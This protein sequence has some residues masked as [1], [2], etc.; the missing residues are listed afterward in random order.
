MSQSHSKNWLRFATRWLAIAIIVAAGAF[1]QAA[2]SGLQLWELSPSEAQIGSKVEIMGSG[3]STTPSLNLVVFPGK[4]NTTA[5]ATVN[6]AASNKLV[7]TVPA[8]SVTGPVYVRMGALTSN[9]LNFVMR[10][11]ITVSAGPNQAIVLPSGVSLHGTAYSDSNAGGK[12][13]PS[14]SQV[15]GPGLVAFSNPSSFDTS[16]TFS[17]AGIYVLRLSVSNNVQAGS[18]DVTI[19]AAPTFNVSAGPLQNLRLPGSLTIS[20]TAS[21]FP[22]SPGFTVFWEKVSGPGI[23]TFSNPAS[24]A[25]NV[26]F[27]AVGTYVLRLNAIDGPFN[28]S[29]D[30]GVIVSPTV[31]ASAGSDQQIKLPSSATL[32]GEINEIPSSPNLS[33]SWSK[34]SGPGEVSFA[35]PSAAV[36]TATFSAWGTYVLRLTASDGTYSSNSETTVT[37]IPTI[38]SVA[39]AN[40]FV[41]LPAAAPL[42]GAATEIPAN[43]G[44]SLSWS[45][46]SGPGDVAFANPSSAATTAT[47]SAWGT[48]VLRLTAT[49]GPHSTSSDTTITAAPTITVNAGQDQNVKLPAGVNLSGTVSETPA[50]AGI[51]VLWS[52][53]SGPG[54][55]IFGTPSATSTTASFTASGKYV[56]RLTA[57][58]GPY[59]ESSDVVV[60]ATPTITVNAG[61]DQNVKL[62]A[63][64]TLTGTATETPAGA[65][66][67]VLWTKVSGPG[68]VAFNN[69]ASPGT[70][71][72]FSAWGT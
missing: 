6:S 17:L 55:V 21:E 9:R 66:F 46:V 26:D 43:P 39:G 30:V 71:A 42:A 61:S 41:K 32:T 48:Y 36:T 1:A 3:F 28:A 47:F 13:V 69:A 5:Q 70:T 31:V 11:T 34:V 68:D 58:D 49:D 22:V 38:T 23:A 56:L 2:K 16:A 27:S 59:S 40:Q 65:G 8:D 12:F 10:P 24:P 52:K 14:W 62:P 45:K 67:A 63:A 33:A 18:S 50:G 7:V 54:D 72:T 19:T 44:I 20:G 60:M 35:N 57:S 4:G 25:T 37:T 64:A 51:A 15:S 53:V 29:S